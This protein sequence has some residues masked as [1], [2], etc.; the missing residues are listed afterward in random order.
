MRAKARSPTIPEKAEEEPNRN[1]QLLLGDVWA[2]PRPGFCGSRRVPP[3]A[4]GGR[5]AYAP[6]SHIPLRALFYRWIKGMQVVLE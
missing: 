4:F 5:G 1:V 6:P 3:P 2:V